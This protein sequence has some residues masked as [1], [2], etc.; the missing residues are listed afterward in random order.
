MLETLP[1]AVFSIL[2]SSPLLKR[3]ASRYGLRQPDG[4]A[5]RFIAG[6]TVTEAIE[7]ARSLERSGLTTTLDYLGEQVRSTTAA[8]TATREYV[9]IIAE[10]QKAG[11]ARSLS[12]KLTQLGLNVDRA[13]SVDN[14]RRILD[15]AGEAGFFVRVDMEQSAHTDQIFDAFET[16]WNIG[17]HNSGIAIQAYL[18]RS[19][20]DIA[21][22][23][24][25]GASV[26][27]VKGAY[28]EPREAAYAHK[29]EVD[30][31]FVSLMRTLLEHG[32]HP[33]IA[34]HDPAM[35]DET[36]R[37]AAEKSIPRDRY[38]FEM[39]YGVRRDLQTELARQGQA[40]R[41][42]LPFGH[43]WFPYFMRRLGERP[44]NVTFVLKSLFKD[45]A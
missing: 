10:L 20:A 14:L 22:M 37:F 7:V 13:T 23:N 31:A 28:S 11:V 5:R 45:K 16:L 27:L 3:L 9:A 44:A 15:A 38:E 32:E 21:R 19:G 17:Y 4:F 29:A 40:V 8:A 43:L 26:R 6:D 1:R 25:L 42:Y 39:L 2:A 36:I 30:A 35:L 34:T 24:A 12:V 41:I 33:A 18:R